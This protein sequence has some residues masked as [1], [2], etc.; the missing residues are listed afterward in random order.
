MTN[1]TKAAIL[2]ALNA[3]F[4]A[5]LSFGVVSISSDTQGKIF[6][7]ANLILGGLVLVTRKRSPRWNTE[8]QSVAKDVTQVVSVVSTVEKTVPKKTTT[9]VKTTVTKTTTSKKK[10]PPKKV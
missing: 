7:S 5:L 2:G 8:V 6:F 4:G 1:A 9:P 3:V 10:V